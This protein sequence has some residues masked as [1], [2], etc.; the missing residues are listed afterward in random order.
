MLSIVSTLPKYSS[1]KLVF[2][3][4]SESLNNHLNLHLR[5]FL[6]TLL[7]PILFTCMFV[8]I[9]MNFINVVASHIASIAVC[10]HEVGD[11]PFS[12]ITLCPDT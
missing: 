10:V 7:L 1:Q 11:E 9:R 4:L 8:Y 5:D 3:C 6:L 12:W 2:I